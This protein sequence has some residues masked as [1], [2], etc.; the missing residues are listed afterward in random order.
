LNTAAAFRN[1]SVLR[2][3]SFSL[4][5]SDDSNRVNNRVRGIEYV[6]EER[7][8]LMQIIVQQSFL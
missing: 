6:D 5:P 8:L 1:S 3:F 2:D 4:S 7:E